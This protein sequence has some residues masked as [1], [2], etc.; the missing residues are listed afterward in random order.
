[1]IGV[2]K[3]LRVRRNDELKAHVV[4]NASCLA[5]LADT[6]DEMFWPAANILAH[7]LAHVAVIG[8]FENH[9][10]GIML[11]QPQ[12]DWATTTLREAAHTIWEEYAACRLSACVSHGEVVTDSYVEGLEL[13]V[14]GALSSAR[15]SIKAYRT[16]A[17]VDRLLVEASRSVANPLKMA[18]Y[19]MGH[20]DGLSCEIDFNERCPNTHESEFGSLLPKLLEALRYAWDTRESWN[21]LK[22]VD[23]LVI[24]IVE[25]LAISGAIVT[26][27]ENEPGSRVD[28]PFTAATMPNGEADM[29]IIRMRKLF[30]LD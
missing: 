4:I 28:V 6:E 29:A 11:S 15:D 14:N 5:A 1:L 13:S 3:T 12:G 17:E 27:S 20:L 9:S 2:G 30:G 7:E 22:G 25:A 18:A 23:G 16:H 21:G 10:P 26:L 8:W 19:L 24:V